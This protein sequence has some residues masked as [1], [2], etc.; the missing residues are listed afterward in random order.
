MG[1]QQLLLIVLGV[2]VVGIAVVVG[3]NLFNANAE[4]STQDSIVSQGT[5]IGAMAQQYFKKPT[6]MGGG[7]NSFVGFDTK[8][9]PALP[10]NLVT[11]TDAAWAT[12]TVTGTGVNS[13][14]SII[15]QPVDPGYAAK[16]EVITLVTSTAI[17]DSIH[18]K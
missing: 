8:V 2:I 6:T 12:P 10:A 1:Q 5:N 7:G 16:W 15:A 18:V 13:S 3:I 11:S 4:S 9:W 14:V 17:R